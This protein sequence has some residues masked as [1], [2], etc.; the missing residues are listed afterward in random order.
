M[1][2]AEVKAALIKAD[3]QLGKVRDRPLTRRRHTLRVT[4]QSPAARSK[5]V[6]FYRVG[7]T[8]G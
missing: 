8:L 2:L 5:H 6:A 1:T 4:R 7:V 3:C